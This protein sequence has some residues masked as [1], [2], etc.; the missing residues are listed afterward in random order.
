MQL[1]PNYVNGR[2]QH[3]LIKNR[4]EFYDEADH[5]SELF[6]IEMQNRVSACRTRI[7]NGQTCGSLPMP[8]GPYHFE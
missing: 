7:Q 5:V 6:R 4:E 1:G 3:R 8:I 2:Y